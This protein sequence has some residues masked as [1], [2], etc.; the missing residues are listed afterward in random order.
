MSA[1]KTI[2]IWNGCKVVAILS[3]SESG[4]TYR[5]AVGGAG[6]SAKPDIEIDPWE[7]L[8][9][10]HETRQSPI[11]WRDVERELEAALE[12]REQND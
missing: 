10:D 12:Q 11:A 2:R 3:V 8:L 9:V 4:T 7:G 5:G 6:N 1:E